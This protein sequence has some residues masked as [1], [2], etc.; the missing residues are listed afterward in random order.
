MATFADEIS[1]VGPLLL[2]VKNIDIVRVVVE[3]K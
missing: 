1:S 3:Q 2:Y